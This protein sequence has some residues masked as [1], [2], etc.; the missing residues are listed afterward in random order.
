V[1]TDCFYASSWRHTLETGCAKPAEVRQTA[2]LGESRVSGCGQEA[3]GQE[4]RRR[5]GGPAGVCSLGRSGDALG[6]GMRAWPEPW[7]DAKPMEGEGISRPATV[8]ECH[9]P[10]SGA[11][12]RGRGSSQRKMYL[13]SGRGGGL[14]AR[15][16]R[17]QRCETAAVG[18]TSSRGVKGAA[19]T[20]P[21]KRR[22]TI[23]TIRRRR[24]G[25]AVEWESTN[26]ANPF[27]YRDA[28]GPESSE[29]R[30]PSRW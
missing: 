24:R 14:T 19:R 18:G 30:K 15:R 6:R 25:Q 13:Y 4:Q 1:Q 8:R 21:F 23:P 3:G 29:R 9:I 26:A 7:R 10:N 20:R 17:S 16:Q 5:C 11:T 12:P 28:T 22:P 27:R 2:V